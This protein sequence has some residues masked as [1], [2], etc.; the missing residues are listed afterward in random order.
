MADHGHWGDA[1]R[2]AQTA[3]PGAGSRGPACLR[4]PGAG[5]ASATSYRVGCHQATCA[6]D[7]NANGKQMTGRMSETYVSD[8]VLRHKLPLGVIPGRASRF[9]RLASEPGIHNPRGL[10]WMAIMR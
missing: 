4:A 9:S 1:S 6:G 2:M 5:A 8:I 3:V 7:Q 10:W